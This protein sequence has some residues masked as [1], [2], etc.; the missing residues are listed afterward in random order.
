M[1]TTCDFQRYFERLVAGD[2]RLSFAHAGCTGDVRRA[3]APEQGRTQKRFPSLLTI[4]ASIIAAV[5][6]ARE[7]I[8]TPRRACS[9]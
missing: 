1:L 4:S 8:T 9:V 7:D 2:F 3:I 6:L 5:R